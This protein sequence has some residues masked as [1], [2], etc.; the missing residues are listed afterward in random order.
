VVL[1]TTVYFLGTTGIVD[2]LM[3]PKLAPIINTAGTKC[4]FR[5]CFIHRIRKV[6]KWKKWRISMTYLLESCRKGTYEN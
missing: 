3:E 5:T 2:A 4:S 1:D 6:E